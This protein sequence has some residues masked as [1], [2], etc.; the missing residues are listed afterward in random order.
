MSAKT[1]D[2]TLNFDMQEKWKNFVEGELE[3]TKYDEGVSSS[4]ILNLLSLVLSPTK[5]CRRK[6]ILALDKKQI[7]ETWDK[8]ISSLK[9]SVDYFKSAFRI[10]VSQLL[11]YDTLLV[12]F[13]YF[14]YK[15]G[16]KKPQE[17]Q[18]RKYL[19]E[20][21]WHMSLSRRYSSTAETRLAVCRTWTTE[22]VEVPS[23][24]RFSGF[25]VIDSVGRR[26]VILIPHGPCE[27]S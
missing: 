11:P 19:Q 26:L 20:F 17:E 21:F 24:E 14:F 15:T 16:G 13:A 3:R 6:T 7:I 4:V 12:P 5:E 9:E 2:E 18:Q 25:T 1:Y 8:A 22:K 23:W 10:P 27:W